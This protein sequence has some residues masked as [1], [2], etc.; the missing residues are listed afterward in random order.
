VASEIFYCSRCQCRLF[1]QQFLE[2]TAFRV[3]DQI[4][5]ENCLGEVV[6]PLSLEEQ[7]EILLQVRA[8]KDSQVL[9]HLPEAPINEEEFFELD[10]P[11]TPP[12]EGDFFELDTPA[13]RSRPRASV[14]VTSKSAAAEESQN[15][16]V[17]VFLLCLA[18]IVAIGFTLYVTSDPDRPSTP[19]GE[20][21]LQPVY[22]PN[23][24]T[25][26][27]RSNPNNPR[28][29]EARVALARARDF[30]RANPIDLTGQ[31]EI[32]KKSVEAADGT[33]LFQEAR[34]DY[35]QLLQRHKELVARD[36]DAIDKE[37]AAAVER[38]DFRPA[39]DRLDQ[40]RTRYNLG[41]WRGGIDL[42][43]RNLRNAIWK[44]LFPLRDKAIAAKQRKDEAELK[45]ITDRVAKWGLPEFS[46][47]LDNSLG[48]GLS[49]SATPQPSSELKPPSGEART[50]E[51]RWRT[52]IDQATQ[53]N[54]DASL[55]ALDKAAGGLREDDVKAEI[56]AD[57][58]ILR[59]V[60]AVYREALQVISQWGRNEKIPLEYLD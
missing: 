50:Y 41:E 51:T 57:L 11:D 40:A 6:A 18:G 16:A 29:D 59:K 22:H 45:A 24:K 27:D 39:M 12:N 52:A 20:K 60:Q 47:D 43:S 3:R 10:T 55:A 19:I 36:L 46:R 28:T 53:R 14:P 48:G 13:R 49:P 25:Y 21:P 7:Q 56:A 38:E 37:T 58:D 31:Q 32:F 2:G 5:C 33:P 8:L 17:T 30:A 1:G 54:Y 4:S 15:R 26:E 35:E 44:A 34:R 42:R 9:E 23:L